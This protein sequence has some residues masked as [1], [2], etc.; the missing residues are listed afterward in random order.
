MAKY[1]TAVYPLELP[2]RTNLGEPRRISRTI[3]TTVL[4]FML[5]APSWSSAR[6]LEEPTDTNAAPSLTSTDTALPDAPP[7]PADQSKSFASSLGT[8]VKT[9]GDDELHIIKAPFSLSA[10]R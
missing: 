5:L 2:E 7:A 1:G 6:A 10:V 8:A 3:C 9:I 4:L